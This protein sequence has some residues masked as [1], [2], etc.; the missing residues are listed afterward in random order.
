MSMNLTGRATEYRVKAGSVAYLTL[1][2]TD[3]SGTA[4][5]LTDD[6]TYATG[7]WKVWQPD[8]TLLING[9][10]TYFSRATGVVSY[11]LTISDTVI[12]NAGVWE[13]E[14]ELV[15]SSGNMSEQTKSFNFIIED[16]Y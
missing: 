6:N 13:G 10:I 11:Q 1:T 7:K 5:S 12:A 9:D 3:S 2:V 15:N 4:K 16:S 8:G 14:V